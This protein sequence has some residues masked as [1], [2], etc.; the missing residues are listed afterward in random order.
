[1]T[2]TVISSRSRE[3][4]IGFDRPFAVIG[5]RINP[6]GRKL[7]AE[8]MKV[9]DYS[10]V[11]ADAIAQVAAV[12]PRL[13]HERPRGH[14]SLPGLRPLPGPEMRHVLRPLPRRPH[15]LRQDDLLRLPG[16]PAQGVQA[17]QVYRDQRGRGERKVGN[18]EFA[19]V[20]LKVSL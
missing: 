5:E 9:G 18:F 13:G 1:M 7:L 10:R 14:H 19:L 2:D 11:E 20:T 3:V 4:V 6:T 17:A 12:E 8:E 16:Q 15:H